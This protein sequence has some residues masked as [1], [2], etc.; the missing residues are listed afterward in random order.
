MQLF[1][2]RG[3]A[4]TSTQDL[5]DTL[6]LNR[7]SLYATFGSKAALYSR[8]L[9]R[10]GRTVQ[11]WSRSLVEGPEPLRPRL[12]AALLEAVEEDLDPRRSRGCF[13]SN[14]AVELAPADPE[15]RRL[16]TGAFSDI[17]GRFRD[18][19]TRGIDDGD[20]PL[21]TDV[22]G[23][24]TFLFTSFEGLRVVAKGTQDRR[25]VEQAI[26]KIVDAL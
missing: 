1:W 20:L 11:N 8:A 25:L 22:D 18:A 21:D 19:V 7:S 6:G 4:A 2:S 13:A 10:Y 16:V 12:R 24:A 5:V 17:R 9:E 3:Y 14:A 26:E 23:L 15:V